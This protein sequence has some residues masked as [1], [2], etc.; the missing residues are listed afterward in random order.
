MVLKKVIEAIDAYTTENQVGSGEVKL[1]QHVEPNVEPSGTRSE[2][3]LDKP[4]TNPYYGNPK[5]DIHI[6]NPY[7]N[8]I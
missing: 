3:P 5:V 7:L 1:D 4:H 8:E 6:F 2:E